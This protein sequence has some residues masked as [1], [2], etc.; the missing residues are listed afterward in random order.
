MR[1]L[2]YKKWFKNRFKTEWSKN[3]IKKFKYCLH[4]WRWFMCNGYSFKCATKHWIGVYFG[5][6][7]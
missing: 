5:L 2:I 4:E 3:L 7:K 6:V 1:K